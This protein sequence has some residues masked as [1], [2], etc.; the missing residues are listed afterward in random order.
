MARFKAPVTA[1]LLV[2]YGS[3]YLCR[4][5]VD[6]ALPFLAR[7]GFDKTSL[8]LLSSIAT[9]TYAVGK[10][11]LGATGDALGGR[12]LLLLAVAGSV[13][14][15][16]AFGTGHG[17]V[18]FVFFAAANRFFQSGGWPGLIQVVSQRFEPV[19]HGLVMGVLSTSY[20]LGNVCALTLSGL[21][22]RWGWHAL[23]VV[24][25]ILFA[26]VG[27]AAVLSLP[28]GP[29]ARM[30]PAES[31]AS[32]RPLAEPLMRRLPHL[33][34]SG[35]FW[36][37]VALS[38][39]LTFIRIGFLTWTPTYLS[40]ISH[41]SGGRGIPGAIVKSAL[42]PAAGVIAA[43]VF[44]V[45]SDRLGP[46]RR[47]P[48][49]AASLTVVVAL[50]LVLA[51]GNVHGALA[52]A[53]LIGA[54]G[55]FLLGPYSLPAGALALDVAGSKGPAT[56]AGIIDGAG[57]LGAT[58]SGYLLGHIA[59]REGWSAAFD[60]VAGAALLAALVSVGWAISAA[61]R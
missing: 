31:P 24:N 1:A 6:A 2:A 60:V 19:R 51:H 8:G 7:E 53:V 47:A 21:V 12:R 44:G 48:L 40:E 35:A 29:G 32:E 20:E 4:A 18:A 30:H 49:M 56:A 26:L 13:G 57:Y 33:L 36:T 37:A 54:I 23:F 58:A 61:R 38:A 52:A 17:F 50:V 14:C 11:V 55:L 28:A 3:F 39:L 25:P 16:F 41:A 10:V 45:L 27:G 59:D 15:S 34:S 5:N 42:F 43:P 22:A 46:G 9:L